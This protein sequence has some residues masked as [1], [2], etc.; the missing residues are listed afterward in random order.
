MPRAE[1]PRTPY[2]V[3]PRQ[4]QVSRARMRADH[5]MDDFLD[6]GTPVLAI[7][8]LQDNA[9]PVHI[10]LYPREDLPSPPQRP[11]GGSQAPSALRKTRVYAPGDAI[12]LAYTSVDNLK[13][14][15]FHEPH[16]TY[17]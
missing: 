11:Q 4:T 7:I 15:G 9:E 6:F 13:D 16:L 3:G 12:L 10:V 8:W 2:S 17:Y 1:S 14:F 5:P